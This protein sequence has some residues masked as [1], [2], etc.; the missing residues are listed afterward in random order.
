V[1]DG[2]DLPKDSKVGIFAYSYTGSTWTGTPDIFDNVA[3]T[4]G[5]RPTATTEVPN[6]AQEITIADTDGKY[7]VT[8]RKHA[9]YSYYPHVAS[10]T[11]DNPVI[12]GDLFTDTYAQTDWLWATPVTG[13]T[14]TTD[15]VQFTYDHKVSSIRV[16]MVKS[17]DLNDVELKLD[18]IVIKT[19]TSQKFEFNALTG[20]IAKKDGGET[21]YSQT[22]SPS[23]SIPDAGSAEDASQIL[24]LPGSVVTSLSFTV[25]GEEFT[26]PTGW[27]ISAPPATIDGKGGKYKQV[28]IT[29]NVY[30]I[31]IE[32]GQKDWEEGDYTDVVTPSKV[33][34][35]LG[36]KGWAD[37]G[38]TG[39]N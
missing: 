7:Y 31:T 17:T 13:I 18:E 8:G 16:A 30:E 5:E 33:T 11:A 2:V 23:W 38:E 12:E 4:V 25:N 24:L 34:I 15:H 21:D 20:A 29:I 35:S 10:V 39:Y 3:G 14:P 32:L 27:T 36:G 19:S 26:T 28:N 6:P 9:F 1:V 37:G 22:F